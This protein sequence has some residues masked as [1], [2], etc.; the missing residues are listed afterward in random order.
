MRQSQAALPHA[1]SIISFG[2]ECFLV[3]LAMVIQVK[4]IFISKGAKYHYEQ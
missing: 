2:H 1:T 3:L 4:S